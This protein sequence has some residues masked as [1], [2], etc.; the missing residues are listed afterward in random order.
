MPAALLVLAILASCGGGQPG[1]TVRVVLTHASER[2]VIIAEVAATPLERATGLMHR[3][4]LS[5]GR[6]MLF[7]FPEPTNGGFWMKNTRIPLHILFIRDGVVTEIRSMQ[8]CEA[9]PCPLTTPAEP[10]EQALEVAVGTLGGI[11]VGARVEVFGR[12]PQPV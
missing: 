12:V 2:L 9:D 8:P 6:G 5:A 3:D 4:E 7:V 11:A 10:Y 1:D